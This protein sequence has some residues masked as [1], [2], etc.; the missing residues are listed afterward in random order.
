MHCRTNRILSLYFWLTSLQSVKIATSMATALSAMMAGVLSLPVAKASARSL[1]ELSR[2]LSPQHATAAAT[3]AFGVDP[4]SKCTS[5]GG[6]M[7]S[8]VELGVTGV[9]QM[10]GVLDNGVL[11]LLL[12]VSVS[13]PSV[14]F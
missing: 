13:A 4:L 9:E 1:R 6:A 12:S 8:V 2:T 10:L 3:R 14:R 7:T 5:F 11:L